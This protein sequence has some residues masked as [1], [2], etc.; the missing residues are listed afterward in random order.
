MVFGG[1]V[2]G[3]TDAEVVGV[4]ADNGPGTKEGCAATATLTTGS[5]GPNA[6]A[7]TE[8]GSGVG[9]GLGIDGV[10]VLVD[11]RGTI[12]AGAVGAGSN[13]AIP[14][15]VLGDFAAE[16]VAMAERVSQIAPRAK[17][18]STAAVRLRVI[19]TLREL[20]PRLS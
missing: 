3:E 7:A 13:R 5:V 11:G 9:R 12:S 6:A 4:W 2:G 1:C 14:G 18:G 16:D 17:R 8:V 10:S 20:T 19:R 15:D